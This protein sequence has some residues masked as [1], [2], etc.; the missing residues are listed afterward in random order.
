MLCWRSKFLANGNLEGIE[1]IINIWNS[2]ITYYQLTKEHCDAA[3]I[4]TG[5]GLSSNLEKL[6]IYF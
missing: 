1:E 2:V 6:G 5:F 4:D 3:L